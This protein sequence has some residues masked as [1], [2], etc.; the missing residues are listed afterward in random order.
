[1]KTFFY[2]KTIRIEWNMNNTFTVYMND[3]AVHAFTIYKDTKQ[4]R[5]TPTEAR[6]LALRFVRE[7]LHGIIG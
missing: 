2:N 4:A 7:D 3:H 5:W 6:R 1:M